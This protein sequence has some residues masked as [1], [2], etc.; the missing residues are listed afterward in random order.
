AAPAI[1]A[2]DRI[3]MS[4]EATR[5]LAVGFLSSPAELAPRLRGNPELLLP[6]PPVLDQPRQDAL[7]GLGSAP[8]G[9]ARRTLQLWTAAT[10]QRQPSALDLQEVGVLGRGCRS[11]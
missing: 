1:S 3:A 4:A 2:K 6:L 11:F 7:A 9:S 10:G 5:H 8:T